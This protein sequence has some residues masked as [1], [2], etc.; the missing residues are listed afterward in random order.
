MN[1]IVRPIGSLLEV[2]AEGF[3]VN[4]CDLAKLQPGWQPLVEACVEAY[5]DN[6][7]AALHSVWLRG[8]VAK[9][10]AIDGFSDLDTYAF[11]TAG[12]PPDQPWTMEIHEQFVREHP[13]C[14]GVEAFTVPVST[15][16][17]DPPNRRVHAMVKLLSIPVWGED[18]SGSL[19]R[20]RPDAAL[21]ET[22]WDLERGLSEFARKVDQDDREGLWSWIL[23]HLIRC[24]FVL[25]LEREGTYGRDLHPCWE[26]FSRHYPEWR[27]RT[28]QA[29]EWCIREP[30]GPAEEGGRGNSSRTW[31]RSY[32]K[33][34]RI[35]TVSEHAERTCELVRMARH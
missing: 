12:A 6:V 3:L 25:V 8:S 30:Q 32:A 9:D 14:T 29:L 13:H 11:V 24:A 34:T 16:L 1:P 22:V 18:V 20:V 17:G 19:A 26:A 31:E 28:R 27:E 10:S 35:S 33:S 15:V 23:R 2:D 21:V 4:E 5:R 7:G